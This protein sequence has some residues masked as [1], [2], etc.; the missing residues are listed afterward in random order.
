[1]SL[2]IWIMAFH[3][4]KQSNAR[5]HPPRTQR[6]KHGVSRMRAALFAVGCMPLFGCLVLEPHNDYRQPQEELFNARRTLSRKRVSATALLTTGPFVSD[7]WEAAR[8][9]LA[10]S[11]AFISIA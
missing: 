10:T 11:L 6:I 9:S 8:R 3:N 5:H 4:T 2:N 7:L 1:M